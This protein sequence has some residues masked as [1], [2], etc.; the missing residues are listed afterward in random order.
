MTDGW[1]WFIIVL[2]L[3]N[4]FGCGALLLWARSRRV[5]SA[6]QQTLGHDYDGIQ[7]L[8][9]PLPRW[10][11]LLFVGSIAFALVYLVLYPGLGRFPGTLGWT[12]SGQH[13]QEV[14]RADAQYGP[15]YAALAAQPIPDLVRDA[16]ALTMGQHL[17]ANNCSQ[18]HGADARGGGGFPDLTDDDWLYGGDPDTIKTSILHG[19]NGVM[20]PFAPAIGGDEGV[21]LVTAYVLSLSGHRVDAAQA[22]AG[23]AKYETICI[24]CH[25]ADGKGNQALGA[26]NLTDDVWLYGNDPATIAEGLNKGR[27]GKMPAHADILGEQKAQVVAAY[28]Y[29]LSLNEP[30]ADRDQ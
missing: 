18:C 22:A 7:E 3:S 9:M 10:W 23:K 14:A 15:L 2:T 11:L 24:A 17:F 19:R 1:S 13:A 21:A 25:G 27:Y 16:R 20:P 5:A 28:V 12:S 30:A 8:D 6:A 4:I 26:P 29:S